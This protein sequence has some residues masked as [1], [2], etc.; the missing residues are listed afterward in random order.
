MQQK[1][2]DE[3]GNQLSQATELAPAASALIT[4]S[5]SE[6]KAARMRCACRPAS[7]AVRRQASASACLGI[8]K[9]AISLRPGTSMLEQAC[10]LLQAKYRCPSPALS[11]K[12]LQ[13][14]A[15]GLICCNRSR[16]ADP[17]LAP[18]QLAAARDH[19]RSKEMDGCQSSRVPK[20]VKCLA[21][22]C[23]G[24]PWR[25]AL[26]TTARVRHWRNW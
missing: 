4:A 13:T 22:V 5:Q 17:S 6:A 12:R 20:I 24:T 3:R 18:K 9:C 7:N 14:K 10:E 26:L 2:R 11:G 21:A 16:I 23:V 25:P 15:S 1:Q 19:I 8:A